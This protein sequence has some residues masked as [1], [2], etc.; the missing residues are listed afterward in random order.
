MHANEYVVDE[1]AQLGV[2]WR[3]RATAFETA[4]SSTTVVW[5]RL[6][7]GW[8]PHTDVDSVGSGRVVD[9]RVQRGVGWR[10]QSTVCETMNGR[11]RRNVCGT[12]HDCS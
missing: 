2:G 1:H 7:V 6:A 10:V 12:D 5:W 3:A 11:G 8:R 9:W 4:S